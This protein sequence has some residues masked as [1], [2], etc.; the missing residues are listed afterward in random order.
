MHIVKMTPEWQSA[1]DLFVNK[2]PQSLLYHSARYMGFL[3]DLLECKQETLLAVEGD[4]VVGALPL[5]AKDGE[6]GRV[7]NSSPFYGS[8]GGVLGC[9][10]GI[11][12]NLLEHYSNMLELDNVAASTIVEN[13]LFRMDPNSVTHDLTDERIGQFTPIDYADNCAENLMASFHQK[14]RNMIR[15]AEKL[16]VVVTVENDQI[17][18]VREVH[19]QNMREIG[20][21][22]K[23]D[24]FFRL[25]PQHFV[26]GVDYKLYIAKIDG[27]C[28]AAILNFYF[29]GT[30]E[31][32][33]PVVRKEYRD[34]QALSLAIF[35]AM[36]DASKDGYLRWNW[37]GTWLS[38]EGVYR[39]KK[40]W[41]TQDFPYTYFIRL[42]DRG[43]LDMP[44]EKILS[45]YPSFYTVPFSMLKG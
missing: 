6:L 40:R 31:Y 22:P 39:F 18:F 7:L 42:V 43:F 41:N 9:D 20:G 17:N 27:E 15:K 29:N 1:Y 3:V 25:V 38:Q 36:T 37:G 4:V 23:S 44:R 8:N 34:S 28:V 2:Q 11:T 14:T 30:V 45:G 5:L 16:G 24:D 21:L 32:Y 12:H 13:P 35:S 19:F 33:T 10:P 26:A